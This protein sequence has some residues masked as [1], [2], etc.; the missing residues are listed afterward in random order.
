[1]STDAE[2]Q[3]SIEYTSWNIHWQNRSQTNLGP[4]KNDNDS[5][6][7]TGKDLA[8]RIEQLGGDPDQPIL[9]VL[10]RVTVLGFD[11]TDFQASD[12]IKRAVHEVCNKD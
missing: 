2:N 7:R 1:M 6:L 5:L 12:A 8:A 3:P 10:E 4:L 9:I 11:S